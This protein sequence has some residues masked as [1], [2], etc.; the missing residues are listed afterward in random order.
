MNIECRLADYTNPIHALS[1]Q[2]LMQHYAKDPM[3]GGAPL[4]EQV[5]QQLPAALA[6]VPDAF[7][8]LCFEDGA[9]IGLANCLQGFS[10]FQCRPLINVHDLVVDAERRNRGVGQRLL[11][12]VEEETRVRNCCKI[13]LEVLQ[14]NRAAVSVYRRFGFEPYQLDPEKGTAL[15]YQKPLN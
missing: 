3:G 10:T 5:L 11:Q 9:A 6:D 2:R 4:S 7:T 13:T 14:E 15:F 8:V 12:C 1:I